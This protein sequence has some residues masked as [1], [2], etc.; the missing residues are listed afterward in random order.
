MSDTPETDANVRHYL[1]PGMR[2]EHA[3]VLADFA[4]KLERERDKATRR[5]QR[6]ERENNALRNKCNRF[7]KLVAETE[8]LRERWEYCSGD[9]LYILKEHIDVLKK[10]TGLV[11]AGTDGFI[12]EFETLDK[13]QRD[14]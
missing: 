14:A 11:I 8:A 4:R 1:A 9:L 2:E 7:F 5:S 10:K 6:L 13:D 3:I 12:G